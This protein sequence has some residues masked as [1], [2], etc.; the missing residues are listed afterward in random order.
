MELLGQEVLVVQ[1]V[2]KE[3][4]AQEVIKA[5]VDHE[6]TKDPEVIPHITSH[7]VISITSHVEELLH[8]CH[9][10]QWINGTQRLSRSKR[11]PRPQRRTWT[12]WRWIWIWIR[13]NGNSRGP[14]N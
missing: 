14:T 6:D 3:K 7:E 11:L 9:R 5:K 1:E 4:W 8:D 12:K 10:L 2:T 13:N